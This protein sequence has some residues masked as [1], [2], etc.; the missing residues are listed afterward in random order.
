VETKLLLLA[1]GGDGILAADLNGLYLSVLHQLRQVVDRNS[2]RLVL[3]GDD[4]EGQ[5]PGH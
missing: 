3:A 4:D 5:D 2:S 1:S